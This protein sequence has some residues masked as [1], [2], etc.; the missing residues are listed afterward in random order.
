[1]HKKKEVTIPTQVLFLFGSLLIQVRQGI[2]W[3]VHEI[4][5]AQT[6][7][8]PKTNDSKNYE[9]SSNSIIILRLQIAYVIFSNAYSELGR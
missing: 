6:K 9:K 8:V 1:M 5:Q 3:M 7:L 4:E 2:W